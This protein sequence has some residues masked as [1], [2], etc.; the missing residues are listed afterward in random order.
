M[1]PPRWTSGE[2]LEFLR[3]WLSE[4]L[5]H[6]ANRSLARFWPALYEAWFARFSEYP[7]IGLPHPDAAEAEPLTDAQ[8]VVLGNAIKA[9]KNLTEAGYDKINEETA[10]AEDA[11]GWIDESQSSAATRIKDARK[12]RMHLRVQI[13]QQLWA[14][15]DPEERAACERLAAA[16][17][18]PSTAGPVTTDDAEPTPE[19][20]QLAIDETSDMFG[21]VNSALGGELSIKVICY[22]TSPA[23]NTFEEAHPTFRD[24]V[25]VPFQ[26]WLKPSFPAH[27]RRARA[28]PEPEQ[29]SENEETVPV[30]HLDGREAP[31]PS[32]SK[33]KKCK[34]KR[35]MKPAAV[36]KRT[37]I[38]TATTLPPSD[39]TP[40]A[41]F[42][43]VQAPIVA[44]DD[45]QI[46]PAYPPL[47]LLQPCGSTVL[48]P[49]PV[50]PSSPPRSPRYLWVR[51]MVPDSYE[52]DEYGEVSGII[53]NPNLPPE[54]PSSFSDDF[55]SED[56]GGSPFETQ[57]PTGMGPPSSPATAGRQAAVERGGMPSGA[58][59]ANIDPELL[60]EAASAPAFHPALDPPSPPVPNFAPSGSNRPAPRP[61]YHGSV[62]GRTA[63][64]T[65][66]RSPFALSALFGAFRNT[67][68]PPPVWH[69]VSLSS[70]ST[71]SPAASTPPRPVLTRLPRLAPSG[72]AAQTPSAAQSTP[73]PTAAAR[74]ALAAIAVATVMPEA[75]AP[76]VAAPTS[77]TPTPAAGARIASVTPESEPTSS[78]PVLDT[79]AFFE[80]RPRTKIPKAA[81]NGDAPARTGGKHGR[82]RVRG[83]AR[84]A[85][86]PKRS[87]GRPRKTDALLMED[88][89]GSA[90]APSPAKRPVDVLGKPTR[91]PARTP[92][93]L[94]LLPS[95]SLH[96]S[97]CPCRQ[98]TP[99]EAAAAEEKRR[100]E[101]AEAASDITVHSLPAGDIV[102]FKRSRAPARRPDGSV[103][104]CQIK[105]TRAEQATLKMEATLLARSAKR[106]AEEEAA[107][108]GEGAA[109]K[110]RKTK[111]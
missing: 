41:P 49:L 61:M 94:P 15:A 102:I 24:A 13:T 76:S 34:A 25:I 53:N 82:G 101:A 11:D 86:G 40:N 69:G 32:G 91:S 44:S 105:L 78:A 45:V 35:M 98:E 30:E 20:R 10:A 36:K 37:A 90:T 2:Q 81:K 87:V 26:K 19:Q 67:M 52:V 68:V 48:L 74:I 9:R 12:R 50:S 47:L 108:A 73:T 3:K 28:L 39:A 72:S 62:F 23:G 70:S 93:P 77:A 46:S 5:K 1:A 89:A 7:N 43:E 31:E 57:W 100:K 97:K 99:E 8:M 56:R 106:R 84:S 85:E 95:P 92:L 75:V 29:E 110:K 103:P 104:E 96:G 65:P 79:P 6:Q 17:K 21:R 88:T 27:V 66:T 54:E 42:D 51:P 38:S 109:K 60:G 80:S 58:T 83:G 22:G 63:A 33:P 111:A 107:A 16:E 14:A 18:L 4:Y 59:F 55:G 64:T 71:S